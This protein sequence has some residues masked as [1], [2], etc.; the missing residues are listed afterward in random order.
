MNEEYTW[1]YHYSLFKNHD[2]EESVRMKEEMDDFA[3]TRERCNQLVEDFQ[4]GKIQMDDMSED[5]Q[6][7]VKKTIQ[8]RNKFC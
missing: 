6:K 1:E 8:I 2:F 7:L 5:E 3:K 4:S